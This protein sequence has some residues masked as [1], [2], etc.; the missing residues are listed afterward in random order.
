MYF[1]MCVTRKKKKKETEGNSIKMLRIIMFYNVFFF[2]ILH[3]HAHTQFIMRSYALNP[4]SSSQLQLFHR[5]TSQI[6]IFKNQSHIFHLKPDC[7]TLFYLMVQSPPIN[8]RAILTSSSVPHP[9]NNPNGNNEFQFMGNYI[10][11]QG[12]RI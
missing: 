11:A 1:Y 2:C 6:S 7:L 8:F 3:V 10:T 5:P 12:S 4:H 9:V